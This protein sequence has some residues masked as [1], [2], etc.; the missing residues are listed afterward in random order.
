MNSL[1]INLQI[2][3]KL[4]T[5]LEDNGEQ[6][7]L[8]DPCN[9][10]EDDTEEDNPVGLVVDLRQIGGDQ[11]INFEDDDLSEAS[12][13]TNHLDEAITSGKLFLCGLKSKT[14]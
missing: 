3:L 13:A 8:T 14:C 7:T 11:T 2:K 4:K 6:S 10:V 12:S 1:C 5:L 9:A